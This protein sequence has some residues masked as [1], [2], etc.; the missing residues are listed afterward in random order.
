VDWFEDHI[1]DMQKK[2]RTV[3]TIEN[4]QQIAECVEMMRK[5]R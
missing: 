5:H 3:E 1:A 4:R 2:L